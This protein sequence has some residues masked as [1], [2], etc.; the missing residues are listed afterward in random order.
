MRSFFSALATLAFVVSLGTGTG[1]AAHKKS[2][3]PPSPMAST[4]T[5]KPGETMVKGYTTKKGKVVKPY[6]RSAKTKGTTKPA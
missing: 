3:A 6:C 2:S 1:L 4:G 5:C